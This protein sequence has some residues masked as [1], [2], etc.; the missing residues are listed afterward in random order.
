MDLG[1]FS[2]S[3]SVKDLAATRAFYE[4]LGF[5]VFHDASDQQYLILRNGECTLGLFEGMFEGNVLTFNPGWDQAAQEVDPFTDVRQIQQQLAD[6]G[7]DNILATRTGIATGFR[8]CLGLALLLRRDLRILQRLGLVPGDTRPAIELF[9][10][11]YETIE[12]GRDLLWF[13]EVTCLA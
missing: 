2:L 10:R 7:I 12:T 11:L 4:K 8:L 5:T 13:D 9:R 6:V 3:L 1:T